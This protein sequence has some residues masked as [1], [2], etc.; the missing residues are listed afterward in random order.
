MMLP[1]KKSFRMSGVYTCGWVWVERVY[2]CLDIRDG[3]ARRFIMD[4]M[5]FTVY[6]MYDLV[7]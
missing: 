1:L 3:A 7:L 2:L 5:L 6:S 4:I